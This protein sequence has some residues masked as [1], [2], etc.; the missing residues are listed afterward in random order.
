MDYIEKMRWPDGQI[1]CVHCGEIGRVSKITR[2]KAG[3]N[4]RTRWDSD[5]RNVLAHVHRDYKSGALNLSATGPLPL[6]TQFF[7]SN[8]VPAIF[9]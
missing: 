5:P 4:K 1:G 9:T 3:D 6:Q 8:I 7:A 2:E